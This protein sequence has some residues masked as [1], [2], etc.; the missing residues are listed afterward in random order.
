M[1]SMIVR[2][3]AGSRAG[4]PQLRP[5]RPPLRRAEGRA[6]VLGRVDHDAAFEGAVVHAGL[7][8]RQVEGVAVLP[9]VG[10]GREEHAAARAQ[11][12]RLVSEAHQ[13]VRVQ[14]VG[15]AAAVRDVLVEEHALRPRL[16]HPE[17]RLRRR[18]RVVDHRE[19]RLAHQ[20]VA[21]EALVG[22]ECGVEQLRPREPVARSLAGVCG[23]QRRGARPRAPSDR[24]TGGQQSCQCQRRQPAPRTRHGVRFIACVPPIS[25][26]R[27][28]ASESDAAPRFNTRPWVL[29][30]LRHV[31]PRAGRAQRH[32]RRPDALE[33]VEPTTA[34]GRL[35]GGPRGP[36]PALRVAR[37]DYPSRSPQPEPPPS[38]LVPSSRSSSTA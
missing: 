32:R 3:T 29:S 4:Q 21:L 26:S 8:A 20:A 35:P 10:V 37:V 16:D 31:T 34:A 25:T 38:G 6:H 11:A 12:R 5:T 30:W 23:A 24:R 33:G 18:E 15:G 2:A 22:V 28:D 27:R 9:D 36:G 19:E 13:A 17:A 14:L 7:E 1:R